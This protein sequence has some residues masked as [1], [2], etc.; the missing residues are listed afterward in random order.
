MAQFAT[1][2]TGSIDALERACLSS[3]SQSGHEVILYSYGEHKASHLY[4][5]RHASEI[6]DEKYLTQFI[7]NG[8]PN[9]AHFSDAFRV[10]MFTKTPYIW[11]DCDLLLVKPISFDPAENLFIREGRKSIIAAMLR[12]ADQPIATRALELILQQAGRDLP[13]AAP[14]NI[15]PK[16]MTELNYNGEVKSPKLYNPVPTNDF[17]KLLLPEF[18]EECAVLCAS[19]ET[20]HLYNNI[21]QKVGY[22]KDLL[23][24]EGS[25]LY[26]RLK[27]YR[28]DA[29]FIGTYPA[30]SVR[31]MVE[32]WQLRFSGKELGLGAVARQFMPAINTSIK[33]RL[34]A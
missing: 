5:V 15:I 21:L 32:G 25:Y 29:G 19:A 1:F 16:A 20:I 22:F 30:R 23:P 18:K 3:F 11:I 10:M 7:T 2:W 13:W 9:I 4:D 26:E 28:D 12:I 27:S 8:Q 33:R 17:Y 31:A 14:Q 24:P 34:W 6:I